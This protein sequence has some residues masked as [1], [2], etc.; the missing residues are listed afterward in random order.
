MDGPSSVN[1]KWIICSYIHIYV[2]VY[3]CVYQ[4][5]KFSNNEICDFNGGNSDTNL[6]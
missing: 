4:M 1:L 3:M 2:C 5:F 6:G